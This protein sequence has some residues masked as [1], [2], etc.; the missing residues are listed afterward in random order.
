MERGQYEPSFG[1]G[2]HLLFP[3][4]SRRGG[5]RTVSAQSSLARR[6]RL[7]VSAQGSRL[8]WR[9]EVWMKAADSLFHMYAV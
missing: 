1:P 2:V 8:G 3:G 5:S 6:Q 4:G 7:W 9:E